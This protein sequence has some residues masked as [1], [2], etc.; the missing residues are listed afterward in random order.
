M[1]R[2]AL[3][4]LAV[5]P[6]TPLASLHGLGL[7]GLEVAV[8]RIAPWDALTQ[9]ALEAYRAEAAD[10][11]LAISSLQAL[12]FGTTG[13]SLL[14]DSAA[15][16]AMEAHLR[17]VSEMA[18]VLGATIGVFGS[19]RNRLRGEM[20]AAEAWALGRERLAR[21]AAAVSQ[22]GFSLGLEPVPPVYGG[23]FLT[24]ADEVIRMVAE[25]DHPGLR[26]HLDTGC[27]TLGGGSIA[28]AIA[29]SGAALGHF[30]IAEPKLGPFDT[31]LPGHQA[32]AAALR[33][34][35]YGGWLAIEMLEQP[36]DPMAAVR[37]AAGFAR[38]T[39]F[40]PG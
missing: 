30:H 14:G 23:D 12:L 31:P 2:L 32:A 1:M 18:A 7:D 22:A 5:P 21:L 8:T 17:R 19:P 36:G 26:V 15:F 6:G 34:A 16:A 38:E 29:S 37:R 35:G 9:A 20:P 4:N 28:A 40:G 27:V 24:K 33:D 10:A 39:Y 3:S 13:L 11:G 25:V